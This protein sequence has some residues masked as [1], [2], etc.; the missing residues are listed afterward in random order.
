MARDTPLCMDQY[1]RIFATTRIPNVPFDQVVTFD[2]SRHV[3][4]M[5]H[6]QFFEMQVIDEQDQAVPATW[7]DPPRLCQLVSSSCETKKPIL[8]LSLCVCVCV[9]VD[10]TMLQSAG[11]TGSNQTSCLFNPT[12]SSQAC[13]Y[14][15]IAV[16][17]NLGCRSQ[18]SCKHCIQCK[19]T[20]NNR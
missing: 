3:V 15:D 13:G 2:G 12:V 9:C 17:P 11:A 7:Y 20:R 10:Y 19:N 6:N 16:T 14:L 1:R 18:S 8:S 5:C 4:V